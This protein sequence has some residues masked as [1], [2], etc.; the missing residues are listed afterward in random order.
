[1]V[2]DF[3]LSN[4]S[5]ER[6][7]EAASKAGGM[8]MVHCEDRAALE[9]NIARL[10]AEGKTAPRFHAESRPPYV[11][12][13]GTRDAIHMAHAAGS[14]MYAVHVSCA[15][16]VDEIRAARADGQAV[17]AETCPHFLALD[18]SRYELP[19]EEAVKF[20]I[21]PPLRSAADGDALWQALA[22]GTLDIVA[23]DHVPDRVAVEKQLSGQAFPEISNG[24]RASRLC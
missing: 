17:F 16:A 1:M 13:D 10:L 4:E 9:A 21:S 23:T 20:V 14:P 11:E 24:A 6:A 22:D 18:E 3:G 2:Y 19:D 12:A 15:A 7:L 8:L 5:I